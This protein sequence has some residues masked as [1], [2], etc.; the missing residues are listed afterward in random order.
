MASM[1]ECVALLRGINVGRAK[2]MA[3][4]DLR[5]LLEGLGF[6]AVRTVLNSG[7]AVFQTARPDIQK[8]TLRIEAAIVEKFGFSSSVVAVTA[9]TLR[10]IMKENGLLA[11]AGDSSRLFVAFVADPAALSKAKAL[12]AESWAPEVFAVGS[13]AAYLW[14]PPGVMDSKLIKAFSRLTGESATM[15]NWATVLKIQAAIQGRR[16]AT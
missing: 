11:A 14:C 1:T 16:N 8:V 4:A 9:E 15:R 13:K 6:S 2:R 3:M 7:N 5:C 12:L 10:T